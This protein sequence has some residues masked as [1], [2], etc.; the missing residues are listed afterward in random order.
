MSHIHSYLITD[1]Y[2]NKSS[3]SC[4]RGVNDPPLLRS[5]LLQQIYNAF[6]LRHSLSSVF[7]CLICCQE[8]LQFSLCCCFNCLVCLIAWLLSWSIR[9]LLVLGRVPTAGHRASSPALSCA[10]ANSAHAMV[11]R[12][13]QSKP[14]ISQV[15]Q[16]EGGE[17]KTAVAWQAP[18]LGA[19]SQESL[20]DSLQ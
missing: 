11:N 13:L 20:A 7:K 6:N 18:D 10:L 16:V 19:G 9:V 12:L 15:L 5:P 14:K 17:I 4:L 3:P 2:I 8:Q 1:Q